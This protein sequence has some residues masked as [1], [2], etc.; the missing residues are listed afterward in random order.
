MDG[1]RNTKYTTD[2]PPYSTKQIEKEYWCRHI[3]YKYKTRNKKMYL[4]QDGSAALERSAQ[5]HLSGR[6][7]RFMSAQP[8]CYTNS[9][10]ICV[11]RLLI[12]LQH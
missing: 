12:N 3:I 10:N 11:P 5:R 9:V 7:N 4:R 2:I 6:F 8:H 1:A